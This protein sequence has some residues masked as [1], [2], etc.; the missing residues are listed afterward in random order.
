[1]NSPSFAQSVVRDM[2]ENSKRKTWPREILGARNVREDHSR[3]AATFFLAVYLRIRNGL[4]ERRT[5][6]SLAIIRHSV[7]HTRNSKQQA[8]K[9]KKYQ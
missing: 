9:D 8:L 1:M 5:S 6:R 3:G 4:R 7:L 2:K